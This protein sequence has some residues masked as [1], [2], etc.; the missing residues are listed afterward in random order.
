MSGLAKKQ[1]LGNGVGK[2]LRGP[3]VRAPRN[4]VLR[5]MSRIKLVSIQIRQILFSGK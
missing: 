4:P 1:S 2:V 3:K 5:I